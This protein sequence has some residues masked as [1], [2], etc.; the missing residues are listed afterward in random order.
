MVGDL[1]LGMEDVLWDADFEEHKLKATPLSGQ[2][3]QGDGA[4]D[5]VR[6]ATPRVSPCKSQDVENGYR[7]GE[8]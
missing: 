3:S 1:A 4:S 2:A 5:G 8:Q 7:H 6:E